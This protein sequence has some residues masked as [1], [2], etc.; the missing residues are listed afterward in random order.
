MPHLRRVHP[1]LHLPP[2]SRT[3]TR[4]IHS[5]STAAVLV[6]SASSSVERWAKT[7]LNPLKALGC[8]PVGAPTPSSPQ[9]RFNVQHP[10]RIMKKEETKT[11]VDAYVFTWLTNL[12]NYLTCVSLVILKAG[13][14]DGHWYWSLLVFAPHNPAMIS[15]PPTV[16]SFSLKSTHPEHAA[17]WFL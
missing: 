13:L 7:F 3:L 16:S 17:Y 9:A 10:W 8:P 6:K 2:L 4:C 1:L 11:Q 12:I 14:K 15:L 5:T